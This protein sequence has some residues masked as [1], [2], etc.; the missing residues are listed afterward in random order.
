M[1]DPSEATMMAAI[2]ASC[3]FMTSGDVPQSFTICSRIKGICG[4]ET[5]GGDEI[6]IRCVVF[7]LP[8]AGLADAAHEAEAQPEPRGGGGGRVTVVVDP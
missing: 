3:F 6:M 5:D 7:E 4:S 8:R 1:T 2:L